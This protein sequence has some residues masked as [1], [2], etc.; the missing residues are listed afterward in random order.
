[1]YVP[2]W[3]AASAGSRD[4][5]SFASYTCAD[6]NA[7]GGAEGN[8]FRF[9]ERNNYFIA[10]HADTRAAQHCILF[11]DH[12]TCAPIR[13]FVLL[14]ITFVFPT[15]KSLTTTNPSANTILE[16]GFRDH[17]SAKATWNARASAD[18]GAHYQS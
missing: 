16:G 10:V 7:P 11:L 2:G 1:N 6:S 13:N 12:P 4:F 8:E 18:S 17:S 3:S 9:A 14:L 5:E 15:F